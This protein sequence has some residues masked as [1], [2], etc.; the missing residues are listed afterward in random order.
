[1]LQFNGARSD[2]YFVLSPFQEIK[3]HQWGF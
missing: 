1:M 3:K 2:Q